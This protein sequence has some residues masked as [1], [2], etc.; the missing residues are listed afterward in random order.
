MNDMPFTLRGGREHWRKK[1]KDGIKCQRCAF[2]NDGGVK[3]LVRFDLSWEARGFRQETEN[4]ERWSIWREGSYINEERVFLQVW[5][6]T[7][8]S[9]GWVQLRSWTHFNEITGWRP[10]FKLKADM[11]PQRLPSLLLRLNPIYMRRVGVWCFVTL[12]LRPLRRVS[13]VSAGYFFYPHPFFKLY[14]TAG[15]AT[16]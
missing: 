15:V 3:P 8:D 14:Y 6:M 12:H 5:G 16:F 9:Y 4:Q 2:I 11:W 13:G 10:S 1:K 7:R